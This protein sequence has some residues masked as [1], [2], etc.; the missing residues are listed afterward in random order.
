MR[1]LAT[2]VRRQCKSYFG[3]LRTPDTSGFS[4]LRRSTPFHGNVKVMDLFPEGISIQAQ[5]FR[6]LDLVPFG[7]LKGSCNQGPLNGIDQHGMQIPSRTVSHPFHKI[8]H[9][10]F[11]IVLKRQGFFSIRSHSIRPRHHLHE[12]GGS[13]QHSP[14]AG[15]D[16]RVCEIDVGW[17]GR[18]RSG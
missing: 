14:G 18:S 10:P 9:L 5:Q 17:Y 2:H 16:Q 3:I 1:L 15:D 13:L 7:F 12:F 4:L 6:R 8:P 11:E